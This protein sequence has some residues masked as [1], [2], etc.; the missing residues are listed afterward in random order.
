LSVVE[1]YWLYVAVSVAT[2]LP[3]VA[4]VYETVAV[5]EALGLSGAEAGETEHELIAPVQAELK[6]A[7][8]ATPPV[9]VTVNP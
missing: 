9:F 4:P 8:A 2:P 7:V 1:G 3:T 5:V 6:F